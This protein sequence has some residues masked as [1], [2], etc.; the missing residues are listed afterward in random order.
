MEE[1]E[2]QTEEDEEV[3]EEEEY[4]FTANWQLENRRVRC[5]SMLRHRRLGL[6]GQDSSDGMSTTHFPQS[7]HRSLRPTVPCSTLFCLTSRPALP[8]RLLLMRT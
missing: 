4:L 1:G 6:R 8:Q 3:E 7:Q 2:T 5:S